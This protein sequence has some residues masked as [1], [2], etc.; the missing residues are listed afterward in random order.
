MKITNRFETLE[1]RSDGE[2]I[3]IKENIKTT[4]KESP[5]LFHWKQLKLWFDEECLGFIDQNKHEQM[6]W[7]QDPCQTM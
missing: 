7:L 2:V 5:G 4:A 1:N 3:N 6:Q